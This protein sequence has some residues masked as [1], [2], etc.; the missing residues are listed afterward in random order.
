[1]RFSI[2]T[3]TYKRAEKL[4][5]AVKSAMSQTYTDWEMIIVNDSPSDESYQPFASSIN[6]S[7]IHYHVNH[8]NRGV[9]YTR[10]FALDH[11]SADSKW[12][13]FLDD[14]DYLAPDALETWKELILS[15]P[16]CNWFLTN[17][18]YKNGV[19]TTK[20]KRADRF[21]AYI[22]DYLLLRR[23]KGDATHI[24]STSCL[25]QVRFSS[26]VKQGEEWLFFYQLGLN[27]RFFYHDHNST[28]TDGYDEQN[29]LN[30]RKRS[31]GERFETLSILLY[32]GSRLGLV[33]H[34]TFLLYMAM[35]FLKL[36]V[37]P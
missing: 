17:R 7:R 33:Y 2:I 5:R 1:M 11:V 6:D 35:R 32:E 29:G 22:R 26:H 3:P 30:F 24:I 4:S 34:P 14:D 36:I 12:I 23:I 16:N 15:L 9:N 28:I 21:Y 19:P 37:R 25:H 8:T 10:N 13:I 31:R 18:A 20:V 27:E